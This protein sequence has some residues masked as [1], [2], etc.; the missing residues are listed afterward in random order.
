MMIMMMIY[1]LSLSLTLFVYVR[2]QFNT[3][4]QIHHINSEKK[5]TKTTCKS[6]IQKK[7]FIKIWIYTDKQRGKG[8]KIANLFVCFVFDN[9]LNPSFDQ[10]ILGRIFFFNSLKIIFRWIIIASLDV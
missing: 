8:E 7:K 9:W 1:H 6:S 4:I 3:C 2:H 5:T 10:S